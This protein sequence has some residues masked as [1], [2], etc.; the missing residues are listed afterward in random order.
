MGNYVSESTRG[1][2]S[3]AKKRITPKI[4]YNSLAA[5]KRAALIGGLIV[6]F[7][8]LL[9]AVMFSFI[10]S[11]VLVDKWASIVRFVLLSLPFL[12]ALLV[13]Y[14]YWRGLRELHRGDGYTIITDTV[15]RVVTDDK[16]VRRYNG[17]G[18]SAYMEHAMYLYVCGRVV[19]SLEETYT[20]S[21]DDVFYVVVSKNRPNVPLLLYNSKYYELGE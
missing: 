21:E 8:L 2:P 10:L 18:M 14:Y 19:I 5:Q 13:V 9:V 20:Y 4:I 1:D 7:A 11:D 15:E 12:I 6:C 16:M 17:H 3:D